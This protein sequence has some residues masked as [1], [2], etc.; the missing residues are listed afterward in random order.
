M[1]VEKEINKYRTAKMFYKNN[2]YNII[3]GRFF[4]EGKENEFIEKRKET[5]KNW[6]IQYKKNLPKCAKGESDVYN[7]ISLKTIDNNALRDMVETEKAKKKRYGTRY[8][9]EKNNMLKDMQPIRENKDKISYQRFK[10]EDNRQYNIINL[11]DKPYKE[12]VNM[13]K[14]DGISD[15]EKLMNGAGQNNTFKTK[16]IYKDPYDQTEKNVRYDKFMRER[17]NKLDN[18][19]TIEKDN[20]FNGRVGIKSKIQKNVFPQTEKNIRESQSF[21]KKKFF[22]KPKNVFYSD[23]DPK[24]KKFNYNPNMN[25]MRENFDKNLEKNRR[26]KK[27][28]TKNAEIEKDAVL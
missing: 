16:E 4:D 11:K 27:Y 7:L 26:N 21:D 22:D 2:D 20:S 15:W 3:K 13:Y 9:V 10:E 17:R 25:K 19:P 14:K 12:H 1:D 18:L 28:L 24:I 6:G 23:N 5:Q 8:E